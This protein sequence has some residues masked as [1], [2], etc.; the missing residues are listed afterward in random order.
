MHTAHGRPVPR[1]SESLDV[2]GEARERYIGAL[3][4]ARHEDDYGDL[5]AFARTSWG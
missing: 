5:I 1:G 4:K 3:L 2:D